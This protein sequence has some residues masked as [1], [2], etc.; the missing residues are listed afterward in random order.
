MVAN[1]LLPAPGWLA[2]SAS[3]TPLKQRRGELLGLYLNARSR[4]LCT[5]ALGPLQTLRRLFEM[6]AS[7]RLLSLG[8]ALTCSP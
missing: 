4:E 6:P 8:I 3:A 1:A 2:I 7:L 5:S